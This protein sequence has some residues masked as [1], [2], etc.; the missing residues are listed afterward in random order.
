[1]HRGTRQRRRI[2]ALAIVGSV[3]LLAGACGGD[4]TDD[5]GASADKGTASSS[6]A[7]TPDK[8][9]TTLAPLTDDR[10]AD[11]ATWLCRPD[12]TDD[13]CHADLD[14]TLVRADGTTEVEPFTAAADPAVDCFYVYP[15]TSLDATPN[16]DLVPDIAEK[17]T[18]ETQAGRF[19]SVCRVYAPMYRSVTVTGLGLLGKGNETPKADTASNWGLAYDDVLAAWRHYLTVENKGRGVVLIGHSQGT[20]HLIR[21]MKEEIDG[22]DAQRLLVGAVLLGGTVS[23]PEGKDVGGSFQHIPVC[24][25]NGEAGCAMTTS[26]FDTT[27]P[28]NGVSLF[29]KTMDGVPAACTNPAALGSDAAAPLDS[30]ISASALKDMAIPVTTPYVRF[31]GLLTGQCMSDPAVTFLGVTFPTDPADVRPKDLGGHLGPGWGMHLLD[32][33]VAMGDYVARVDEQAKAYAKANK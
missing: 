15:T 8:S 28:P 33:N 19:R 11:P 18:T 30:Y 23:L 31:E 16:S 17:S 12:A 14:A 4:T 32:G 2:V 9:T 25:K 26:T 20:A 7:T 21:L 5:A 22:K 29:G 3:A 1:M 6:A 10:Y 24:T 27:D 13:P